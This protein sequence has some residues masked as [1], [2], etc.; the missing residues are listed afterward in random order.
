MYGLPELPPQRLP[1]RSSW[2]S[3]HQAT[4]LH[5]CGD[6]SA[7]LAPRHGTIFSE[8]WRVLLGL[9]ASTSSDLQLAAG[10]GW[11]PG[12]ARLISALLEPARWIAS[13]WP[14]TRPESS[15]PLRTDEWRNPGY[16]GKSMIVQMC[17]A[18]HLRNRITRFWER[19][20]YGG[21]PTRRTSSAKRGSECRLANAGLNFKRASEVE[22]SS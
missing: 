17:L 8:S 18:S 5:S 14:T 9:C 12:H 10:G 16:S 2:K 20:G 4:P 13:E 6:L 7:S 21:R 1:P 22:R 11:L 3:L 15:G 19:Q